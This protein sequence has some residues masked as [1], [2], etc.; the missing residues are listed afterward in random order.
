MQCNQNRNCNRKY[1]A[2]TSRIH[3][4]SIPQIARWLRAVR[5]QSISIKSK[6]NFLINTPRVC[7]SPTPRHRS[8]PTQY[9]YSY[10]II[11]LQPCTTATLSYYHTCCPSCCCCCC[12]CA[13][14]PA[15]LLS[16]QPSTLHPPHTCTWTT[17]PP[18]PCKAFRPLP[19]HG[20]GQL[21]YLQGYTSSRWWRGDVRARQTSDY[22]TTLTARKPHT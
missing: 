19:Y 8:A 7:P 15:T 16:T 5:N 1:I 9:S 20:P 6:T 14:A 4:E 17:F 12:T 11:L 18:Q 13:T 22:M 2:N 10:C 3:G 21:S